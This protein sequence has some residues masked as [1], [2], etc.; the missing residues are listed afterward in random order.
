MFI[1]F[2]IRE[3]SNRLLIILF[4]ILVILCISYLYKKTLIYIIIKPILFYS[5]KKQ[6]IYFIYTN[7]TELFLTYICLIS[8]YSSHFLI[9]FFLINCYLFLI[10]G[11]YY[12]EKKQIIFITFSSIFFLA[13]FLNGFYSYL[14]P[15][16]WEFF[17]GFN[18]N[19]NLGN[20]EEINIYFETKISEYIQFF[21]KTYLILCLTSQFLF[22]FFFQLKKIYRYKIFHKYKNLRETLYFFFFIFATII[23]PPDVVTQL[24]FGL[25][26]IMLFEI[27][28]ILIILTGKTKNRIFYLFFHL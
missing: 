10:P 9:Y 21:I 12:T 15:I 28:L 23:T 27:L 14:L 17:A 20:V 3:I 19:M 4:N 1:S 25:M 16:S 7:L 26:L 13:F 22:I 2:Y 6:Y 8:F 5:Y 18:S 24:F 11:I